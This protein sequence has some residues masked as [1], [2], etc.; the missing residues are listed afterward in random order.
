MHYF[1]LIAT[2]SILL[3]CMV[4]SFAQVAEPL[5]TTSTDK[6]SYKDGETIII[7]GSVKAIVEGT[8]LTVQILDPNQN[9]V[10]VDQNDVAQDGKYTTTAKA[11]G[12]LWKKDG[13]Y[14]VK[15]QYGPPNVVAEVNFEFES[16]SSTPTFEIFEVDAGEQGTF[17][18][19]YSIRGGIVKDMIIDFEGLSLIISIESTNEGIITLKMPRELID[20]KTAN[21]ADDEFIILID[22]AQIDF[23]EQTTSSDRTITINFLEGDS[24]IEIIGTY[25]APEFGA[26]AALVLAV[27]IISIIALSAKTRLRLMPKY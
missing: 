9:I 14:T 26:I 13:T 4:P 18:V 27:A 24:D 25:V 10:W 15:V 2:I 21:D 23:D 11:T 5:I 7:S 22:G 3:T 1:L 8:P 12:P 19:E 16:A 17:D 20:A 6:T